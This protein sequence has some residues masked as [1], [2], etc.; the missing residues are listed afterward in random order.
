MRSLCFLIPT[1][2]IILASPVRAQEKEGE[3]YHRHHVGALFGGSHNTEKNGFTVGGDYEFRWSRPVGLMVTGEYVAGAFREDLWAVTAAIH[4]WKGL[5][6]QAGPGFEQEFP[7][8]RA[9]E[10]ESAEEHGKRVRGLFR[11]GAGYEFEVNERMTIGPDFAFD[12]LKG[13]R[14]FVYGIVVGFGFH[15]H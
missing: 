9:A 1:I 11:F 13:E 3:G 15:R 4:P 10:A 8:R 6:L 5:K 12:I 14:V 2:F 7:A